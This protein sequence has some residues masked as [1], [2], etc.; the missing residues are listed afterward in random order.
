M[1]VPVDGAARN[2][3]GFDRTGRSDREAASLRNLWS[4]DAVRDAGA[5]WADF[6]F[7]RFLRYNETYCSEVLGHVHCAR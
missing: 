6:R 1:A 4:L 2:I 3:H 7:C 5:T